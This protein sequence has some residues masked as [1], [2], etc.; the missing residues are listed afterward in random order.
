[1]AVE[2]RNETLE[3]RPGEFLAV[4][5]PPGCERW[6]IMSYHPPI[7]TGKGEL[8]HGGP[9]QL[10][11]GLIEVRITLPQ[12]WLDQEFASPAEA[13][14]FMRGNINLEE[15]KATF[16]LSSGEAKPQPSE[17]KAT[18]LPRRAITRKKK[19]Q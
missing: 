19:P 5:S 3:L 15:A 17:S 9:A 10:A 6:W 18:A 12:S 2:G 11:D 7:Y 16:R 1:M 13:A 4:F 14:A 8:Y